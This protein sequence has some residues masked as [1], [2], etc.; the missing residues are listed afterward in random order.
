MFELSW[1]ISIILSVTADKMLKFIFTKILLTRNLTLWLLLAMNV[2][3]SCKKENR[4]DD[5]MPVTMLNVS[6]GE[7]GGPSC[8]ATKL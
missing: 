2:I 7:C 1:L 6:Y 4:D 5:D 3:A 8:V